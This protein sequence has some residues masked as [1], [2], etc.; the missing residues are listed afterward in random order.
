[1]NIYINISIYSEQ[2]SKTGGTSGQIWMNSGNDFMGRGGARDAK[3]D[4]RD[5]RKY[6]KVSETHQS[7]MVGWVS[8]GGVR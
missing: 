2:A 4:Q 8:H 5:L 6:S 1:M 7:G 3:D